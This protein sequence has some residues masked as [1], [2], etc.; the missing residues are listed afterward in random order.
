MINKHALQNM[1][2]PNMVTDMRG[3][4]VGNEYKEGTS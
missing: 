2:V 4:K 3:R 1:S